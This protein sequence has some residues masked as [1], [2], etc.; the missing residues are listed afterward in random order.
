VVRF[1]P[2]LL[3][4]EDINPG[5]HCI[6]VWVGPK[7]GLDTLDKRRN[8]LSLQEIEPGSSTVHSVAYS[9]YRLSYPG[10]RNLLEIVDVED[11]AEEGS[12]NV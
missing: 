9:L 11:P 2:L 7:V 5:T 1:T 8:L 10:W 4:P 3:H 6:E 12:M